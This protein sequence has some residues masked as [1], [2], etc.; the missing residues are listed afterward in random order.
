M[1]LDNLSRT[2]AAKL[3]LMENPQRAAE[4]LYEIVQSSLETNKLEEQDAARAYV[5]QTI[6]ILSGIDSVYADEIAA[7]YLYIIKENLLR[8]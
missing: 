3:Y 2:L 1:E 5:V 8:Y 7:D 4:F 6:E